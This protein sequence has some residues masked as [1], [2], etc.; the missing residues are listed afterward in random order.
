M[1]HLV[2]RKAPH[3]SS[4]AIV[5]GSFSK[6]F[7]LDQYIGNSNVLFFFYPKSFTGLCQSELQ[8]FDVQLDAFKAV[9]TVVVGCS[10]DTSDTQR[11]FMK[12]PQA[13]GG[14]QGVRYPLVSDANKTITTN[15]D[16]LSGEYDYTE[17]GLLSAD[18]DMVALRG[19]FLIDKTGVVQHQLINFYPLGRSVDEA[20]RMASALHHV[21]TH[22]EGCPANWTPAS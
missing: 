14:I 7:S 12:V 18:S 1:A 8:A 11:A 4:S 21:Q 13:E 3:F 6:G 16:V 15:Y 20:L 17:D 2:G 9:D 5:N 10:T 22:G 19:L